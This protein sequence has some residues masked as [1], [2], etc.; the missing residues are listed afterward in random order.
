MARQISKDEFDSLPTEEGRVLIDG[1]WYLFLRPIGPEGIT[2]HDMDSPEWAQMIE[3]GKPLLEKWK[4]A[5][6]LT[7]RR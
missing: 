2:H 3:D 4:L 6:G 1:A 7:W 5:A